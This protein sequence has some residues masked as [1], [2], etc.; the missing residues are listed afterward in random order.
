M[1]RHRQS[2]ER[3]DLHPLVRLIVRSSL[4]KIIRRILDYAVL[5]ALKSCSSAFS[6]HPIG[7]GGVCL[8]ERHAAAWHH[9]AVRR[10]PESLLDGNDRTAHER[11]LSPQV[12]R[13]LQWRV[14]RGNNIQKLFLSHVV[15]NLKIH[16]LGGFLSQL[17]GLSSEPQSGLPAPRWTNNPRIN[18]PIREIWGQSVLRLPQR[19]K[20]SA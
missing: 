17:P 13:Q 14:R 1:L 2:S 5:A 6:P 3:V 10:R 19:I 7:R 16:G 12:R 9:L 11:P 4:E 15:M 18:L 20:K 8:A